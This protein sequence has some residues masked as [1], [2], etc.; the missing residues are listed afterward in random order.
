MP[1]TLDP[2]RHKS[3]LMCHDHLRQDGLT[4]RRRDDD[5]G[6]FS[7]DTEFSVERNNNGGRSLARIHDPE[8][9]PVELWEPAQD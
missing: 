7:K 8:G 3:L 6:P 2:G 4:L 1:L 5:I 9:N